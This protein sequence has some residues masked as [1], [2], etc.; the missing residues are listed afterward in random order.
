MDSFGLRRQ[1][2]PFRSS[3]TFERGVAHDRTRPSGPGNTREGYRPLSDR[4]KMIFSRGSASLRFS[5]I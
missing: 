2:R 5:M 3:P 1:S 4:I